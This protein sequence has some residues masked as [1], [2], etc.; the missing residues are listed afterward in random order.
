MRVDWRRWCAIITVVSVVMAL[1]VLMGLSS[2][3]ITCGLIVEE[4]R[5]NFSAI[6][7]IH[8][9]DFT[10]L[11]NFA[12]YMRLEQ[13]HDHSTLR[14][15]KKEQ[16]ISTVSYFPIHVEYISLFSFRPE[17]YRFI[18]NADCAEIVLELERHG[19]LVRVVNISISLKV[20][21]DFGSTECQIDSPP[22][23]IFQDGY[24]SCP[25][26]RVYRCDLKKEQNDIDPGPRSFMS[27]VVQRLE[28]EIDG[29]PDKIRLDQFSKKI[30]RCKA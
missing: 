11:A 29:N 9:L 25:E 24:Y 12:G 3:T 28:F 14:K 17:F 21:Y 23:E 26:K 15:I 8:S 6:K 19:E 16:N 13:L 4:P 5:F 7:N 10:S 30:N 1:V 20:S 18:I 22:I 27:L 2:K